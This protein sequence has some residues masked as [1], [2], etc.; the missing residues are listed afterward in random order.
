MPEITPQEI[1]DAAATIAQAADNPIVQGVETVVVSKLP[2]NVRGVF[3][4]SGKWIGVAGVVATTIA[5]ALE[6]A[7]ALYAAAAAAALLALNSFIA[8]AHLG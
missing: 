6:G 4:E 5:G 1:K 8:K 3:Y 2:T 7:P